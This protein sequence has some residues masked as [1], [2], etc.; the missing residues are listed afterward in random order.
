MHSLNKLCQSQIIS[1]KNILKKVNKSI[2]HSQVV[3]EKG[4]DNKKESTL[5]GLAS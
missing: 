1:G 3:K 4:T 5:N 2:D